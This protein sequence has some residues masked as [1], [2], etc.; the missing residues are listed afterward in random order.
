MEGEGEGRE[1]GEIVGGG[2]GGGGVGEE[3][4]E[5]EEA[6]AYL[7]RGAARAN[8]RPGST[9]SSWVPA[10]ILSLGASQP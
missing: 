2:G 3:E 7:I 4:E 10:W 9:G 5:V 1:S 8:S 6:A